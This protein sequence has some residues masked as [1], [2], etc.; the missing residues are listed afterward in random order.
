M[1][2]HRRHRDFLM[3][4]YDAALARVRAESCLG[5]HLPPAPQDGRLIILGAGKAAADMARV[6]EA[7]YRQQLGADFAQLCTGLVVTRY[8][9]GAATT[10]IEVVEAGHP[11]PDAAGLQAAERI[12][13]LAESATAEDL[14]LVLL[15]GGGSALLSLPR[16]GISLEEKR[17]LTGALMKK[18]AGIAEL[19]TVRKA[20]SAIKGGRLA[21]AAAPARVITLA[22]SDVPGDDPAIIASGPTVADTAPPGRAREILRR[23]G[24][25]VPEVLETDADAPP[26]P[27][28]AAQSRYVLVARPADALAAAKAYAEA[29]GFS[30]E[31]LGD[32]LEGEAGALARQHAQMALESAPAGAGTVWLSGGEV[33][34]TADGEMGEG[35]PNQ[36]YALALCQALGGER[37]IYALSCDTD[38][39]D[40][41]RGRADDPAG[42]LVDPDTLK[43]ARKGGFDAAD[44]LARHDS[45]GFFSQTGDLVR[46]GPS[47]TNVNDFR[48]ILRLGATK[49]E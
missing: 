15:S 14:V 43:R 10:Q 31:V 34:V 27:P 37:S 8:G 21:A 5:P 18:G 16:P 17:A 40:G 1:T 28:E 13:A 6:A 30:V 7:H 39:N 23:Y 33:T 36:E 26:L 46:T 45:G 38:G 11:N 19:N 3:A 2:D 42:A 12:L 9:H 20:L 49:E 32:D 29:A 41:G 44:F 24:L 22:V 48:A 47:L 35:G 25:A 4:L